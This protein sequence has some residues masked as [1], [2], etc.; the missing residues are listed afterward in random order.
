MRFSSFVPLWA[1]AAI[2][3]FAGPPGAV[4]Q[5]VITFADPDVVLNV[6][7]GYGAANL[8]KDSDGN[9]MVSGRLEGVKYSIFFYSCNEGANCRSMQFSTG[10]TD[11]FTAAKANEWNYKF[12]WIK[13]YESNG[14]NFRMDVDFKGGITRE[15]LDAQFETWNS[16]ISEIKTFVT[17][18]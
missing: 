8:D 1:I 14:S 5:D 16:L 4:A 17:G 18:Q 11:P 3:V 12:R 15:N 2:G 10:Y 6:A 9:P 13:A 7:K